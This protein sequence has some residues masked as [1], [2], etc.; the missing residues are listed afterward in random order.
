MTAVSV[1]TATTA[2]LA[3]SQAYSKVKLQNLG[4]A[5]A[6]IQF[7]GGAAVAANGYSLAVNGVLDLE[8]PQ[9]N[10]GINGITSSGTAD[11]RIQAV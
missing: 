3:P 7:D 5:V 4:A 1:T 2:I 6:F 9:C 11:I 10:R 8:G